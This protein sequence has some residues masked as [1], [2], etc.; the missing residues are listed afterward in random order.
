MNDLLDYARR[1]SYTT[2]APNGYAPGA[3][4]NGIMPP[5]P[6]EEHFQV[7]NL[8]RHAGTCANVA[9]AWN[10]LAARVSVSQRIDDDAYF[11]HANAAEVKAKAKAKATAEEA[12]KKE[13][14]RQR[15]LEQAAAISPG[16]CALKTPTSRL[17]KCQKLDSRTDDRNVFDS[18]RGTHRSLIGVETGR[19]VARRDSTP[20]T[21]LETRGPVAFRFTQTARRRRRR[22]ARE[23]DVHRRASQTRPA[24]R[25]FCLSRSQPRLGRR[26][27]PFHLGRL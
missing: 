11:F 21:G 15:L 23:T 26:R 20:S 19:T 2:H 22:F 8:A 6:Q 24:R 10:I 4:L 3:P 13:E 14:E 16:T 25:T 7:S 9:R 17:K 18:R 12:K 5:A 1:I 27:R